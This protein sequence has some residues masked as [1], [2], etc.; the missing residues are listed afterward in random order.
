MLNDER[1]PM[2]PTD[3]IEPE[4]DIQSLLAAAFE[5]KPSN[6]MSE[7]I[8]RRVAL[9]TTISEFTQMLVSSPLHWLRDDL[10]ADDD[11]PKDGE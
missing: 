10:G 4:V 9:M 2:T 11:E 3:P 5:R 7:R 1:P 6:V 8:V